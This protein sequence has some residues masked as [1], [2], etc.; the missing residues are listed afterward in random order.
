MSLHKVDELDESLLKYEC[1]SCDKKFIREHI[2][3]YQHRE[4][5]EISSY[6]KLCS[7]TFKFPSWFKLH[8]KN[9]HTAKEEIDAFSVKIE[10]A[11]LRFA[12][13]FCKRRFLTQN[14]LRYHLSN[15]HK[16]EKRQDLV[17]E[18]CNKVFKWSYFRKRIMEKH[19]KGVKD[20]I[21]DISDSLRIFAGNIVNARKM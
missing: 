5:K 7:V 10:Q 2:L 11:S 12:C 9:I 15:N 20:L 8:K 13:K 16:E 19:M 17:C 1:T 4:A 6:C 21:T 14:I 3:K 18:F